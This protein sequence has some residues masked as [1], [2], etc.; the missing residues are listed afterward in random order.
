MKGFDT[1][2]FQILLSVFFGAVGLGAGVLLWF[3]WAFDQ[4]WRRH[5]RIDFWAEVFLLAGVVV[6]MAVAILRLW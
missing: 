4:E 2:W 6:A 5:Y 3:L 1:L